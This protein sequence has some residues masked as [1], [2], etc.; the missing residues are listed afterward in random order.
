M[1]APAQ[2]RR[3]YAVVGLG[4]RAQTFVNALAGPY[5]DRAELVGFCDVNQTRMA[6]HNRWLAEKFGAAAV[7]QYAAADFAR[8]LTEQRVDAVVVTSV[9]RTHD[10]YIVD[11]ARGRAAT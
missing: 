5:A 7:P 2:E 6:V 11:R 10:G 9:D 4:G 3:R 1:S 8:M